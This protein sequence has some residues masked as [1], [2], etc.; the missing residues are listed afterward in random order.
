MVEVSVDAEDDVGIEGKDGLPKA[1]GSQ[2][3][4]RVAMQVRSLEKR[5]VKL[6]EARTGFLYGIVQPSAQSVE[7]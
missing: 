7:P 4:A 5:E 6:V 3:T 2:D 1:T